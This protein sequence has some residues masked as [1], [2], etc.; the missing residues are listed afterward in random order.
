MVDLAV[1]SVTKARLLWLVSLFVIGVI[2]ESV[3]WAAA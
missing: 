1:E 2:G 3:R